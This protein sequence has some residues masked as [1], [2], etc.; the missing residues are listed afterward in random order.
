MYYQ[1]QSIQIAQAP[2][3]IQET[4]GMKDETFLMTDEVFV[5]EDAAF[6]MTDETF[7][8]EDEAFL[9]EGARKVMTGEAR[10]MTRRSRITI[11]VAVLQREP[12]FYGR[13]GKVIMCFHPFPVHEQ[14]Y[15]CGAPCG[16]S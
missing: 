11:P 14:G 15:V 7:I 3:R 6:V 4:F 13:G 12:C 5:M 16:N 10:V 9:M 1:S 2:N 8:M